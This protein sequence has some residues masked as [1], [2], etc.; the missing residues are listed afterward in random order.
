MPI[1]VAMG[2]YLRFLRP[3]KVMEVSI[4]GFLLIL[5]SIFGGQWVSE[6]ASWAPM[7]T[8]S[9][10]ALAVGLIIYG[11]IASVTPVWILLAPRGYLSPFVQV[12][13]VVLLGLGILFVRPTLNLPPLTR[14][15]DGTG[16]VFAGKIFPFCFITIACGAI[17]GFH[18]LISSGTTPK[19]IAKEKDAT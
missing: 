6:S 8:Y 14:F 3:G 5:A 9:G 17:S 16:P 19:L 11:F 10:I 4:I 13:V 15:I 12:G 2:I 7:F 1:A 18:S